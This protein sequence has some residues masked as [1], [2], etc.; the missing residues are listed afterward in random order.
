MKTHRTFNWVGGLMLLSLCLAHGQ[1]PMEISY[2]GRLTASATNFAGTGYFKF[3][4]VDRGGAVTYWSNDGTGLAGGE[5]AQPV[6][7]T[8]DNGLF[9]VGLGNTSLAN[10]TALSP[11]VFTNAELFLRIWFGPAPNSL[12]KLAPDQRVTSVGYAMMTANV[13]DGSIRSTKLA[14]GAIG[15]TQLAAQSVQSSNLAPAAVTSAAIGAG[16]I[17][18]SHVAANAQI[19]DTKLA[20]SGNLVTNFNADLL[21]GA[22]AA[23]LGAT[24]QKVVR[25]FVSFSGSTFE[26]SQTFSPTVD[27]AKSYVILS[28]A[29]LTGGAAGGS[30]NAGRTG[31]ALIGLTTNRITIAVDALST[32]GSLYPMRVS[33]QIIELK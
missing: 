2:Q 5:P 16:A 13:P 11:L 17:I 31:A 10:M 15:S 12:V 33:Y 7:L 1:V 6:A 21:D 23:E 28:P 22:H 8:V 14:P 29:I 4:L 26:T 18:D 27:P 9:T 3:S 32:S 24:V 19:A 25:G 30:F 20:G